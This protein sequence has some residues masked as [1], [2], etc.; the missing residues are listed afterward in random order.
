MARHGTLTRKDFQQVSAALR[1]LLD[2]NLRTIETSSTRPQAI[3]GV[4]LQWR[5]FVNTLADVLSRSST[6]FDKEKFLSGCIP[7]VVSE[8]QIVDLEDRFLF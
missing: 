4:S 3:S 2:A 1:D 8:G 6:T 5:N 7:D